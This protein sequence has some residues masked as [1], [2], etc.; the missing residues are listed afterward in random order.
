MTFV[1]M[2]ISKV[3]VACAQCGQPGFQSRTASREISLCSDAW[4]QFRQ[5]VLIH[6]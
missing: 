2:V 3:C 6:A 4:D 1:H 5:L